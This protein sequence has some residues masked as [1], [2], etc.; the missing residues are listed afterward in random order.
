MNSMDSMIVEHKL[1]DILSLIIKE[2]RLYDEVKAVARTQPGT[3]TISISDKIDLLWVTEKPLFLD[4]DDEIDIETMIVKLPRIKTYK[5]A[6]LGNRSFKWFLFRVSGDAILD[7]PG[8]YDGWRQI[9]EDILQSMKLPKT[10]DRRLS[11]TIQVLF[12]INWNYGAF[13]LEQA[14][15]EHM[16]TVLDSAI[17]F[18]GYANHVQAT[19]CAAYMRQTWGS[20]GLELL[21]ILQE[22]ITVHGIRG[23]SIS[24]QAELCVMPHIAFANS[25][26]LESHAYVYEMAKLSNGTSIEVSWNVDRLTLKTTGIPYVVADIGEQLAWLSTALSSCACNAGISYRMPTASLVVHSAELFPVNTIEG[27]CRIGYLDVNMES[28]TLDEDVGSCW[29]DMVCNPVVVA[30]YPISRRVS[31]D[32]GLDISPDIMIVLANTKWAVN[33]RGRTF[34][35]GPSSMLVVTRVIDNTIW[36]HLCLNKDRSYISYEEFRIPEPKDSSCLLDLNAVH[37]N[38]HVVGWCRNVK[39]MAG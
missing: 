7:T 24:L 14:Y 19:T 30:G 35:K 2:V 26:S 13:Y 33:F 12:E 31:P 36:W 29:R 3:D 25:Y 32:G 1:N 20:E 5:K 21:R 22:V 6:L 23:Q 28:E 17:T 15:T 4:P 8:P 18:T 11:T 37:A 10:S 27:I 16:A 39:K 34:I 9:R 38:R